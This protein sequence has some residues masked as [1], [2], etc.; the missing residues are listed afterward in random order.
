MFD[1]RFHLP[2]IL[3]VIALLLSACSTPTQPTATVEVTQPTAIE[4]PTETEP[5]EQPTATPIV[6]LDADLLLWAPENADPNLA[7]QLEN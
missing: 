1:K 3:L 6:L 2:L 4:I 5:T 7:E